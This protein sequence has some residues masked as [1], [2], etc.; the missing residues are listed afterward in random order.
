MA[1]LKIRFFSRP[2]MIIYKAYVRTY[3]WGMAHV[4]DTHNIITMVIVKHVVELLSV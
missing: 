1:C 4:C 3:A 2:N